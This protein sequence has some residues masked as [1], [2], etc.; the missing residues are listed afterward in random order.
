MENTENTRQ[1]P[2]SISL[3]GVIADLRA[4]YTR[5]VGD[6]NYN[7]EVGSIEEKYGLTKAEVGELFKHPALKNLK[8]IP[9]KEVRFVI[10]EDLENT[11]GFGT[12][13]TAAQE[14]LHN[15]EADAVLEQMTEEN[16]TDE[17]PVQESP[18]ETISESF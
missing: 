2:I 18:S 5:R 10:V 15:A 1:E 4:G 6:A 11:L 14:R 13:S 9:K 8:T 16:I 3:K 17:L 7:S 12:P